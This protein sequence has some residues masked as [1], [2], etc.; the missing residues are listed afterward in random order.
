MEHG[1]IT[2]EVQGKRIVVTMEGSSFRAIYYR[3][4]DGSKLLQSIVMS[5]DKKHPDR[6]RR[7]KFE[8]SAWEA[9]N[10]MARELGWI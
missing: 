3:S 6:D 7:E 8:Q 4:E 9:A 1:K 10:A 5:I 2:A